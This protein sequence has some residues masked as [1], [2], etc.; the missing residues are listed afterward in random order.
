MPSLSR[1]SSPS[2]APAAVAPA[3]KSGGGGSNQA[4]QDKMNAPGAD[5]NTSLSVNNLQP[6]IGRA[7]V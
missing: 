7:H 6:Q 5:T 2:K 3:T 4:A 1:Q